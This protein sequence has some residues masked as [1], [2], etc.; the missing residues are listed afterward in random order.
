MCEEITP[1]HIVTYASRFQISRCPLL[2]SQRDMEHS[3]FHELAS[4]LRSRLT[5]LEEEHDRQVSELQVEI[6]QLRAFASGFSPRQGSTAFIGVD[7][8]SVPPVTSIGDGGSDD[9]VDDDG[10]DQAKH[11]FSGHGDPFLLDQCNEQA[12][13]HD[14]HQV[15]QNKTDVEIHCE[16]MSG[17]NTQRE[18][19]N[20]T[21]ESNFGGHAVE[22]PNIVAEDADDTP[23]ALVPSK[24]LSVRDM[25][26]T[27][28]ESRNMSMAQLADPCSSED[29]TK[30]YINELQDFKDIG[31]R[32]FP[33][34]AQSFS[35]TKQ[36]LSRFLLRPGS[37]LRICW[38]LLSISG[39]GFDMIFVPLQLSGLVS[40]GELSYKTDWFSRTFW[41]FD[42]CASFL[43][44]Y[45]KDGDLVMDWNQIVTNYCHT[46]LPF[47]MFVVGSDWVLFIVSADSRVARLTRIGKYLRAVRTLRLFRLQQSALRH[48]ADIF[49]SLVNDAVKSRFAIVKWLFLILIVYHFIACFWYALGTSN[50]NRGS[51]SWTDMFTSADVTEYRYV[52]SLQ[53]T[54]SYFA[55]T[56][57]GVYPKNIQER[58]FSLVMALFSLFVL[59]SLVSLV[60]SA[61]QSIQNAHVHEYEKMNQLRR[62][63]RAY[64][65][66]AELCER[67]TKNAMH[68][69]HLLANRIYPNH[70]ELLSVVSGTLRGE[71]LYKVWEKTFLKNRTLSLLCSLQMPMMQV[72]AVEA[73]TVEVLAQQDFFFRSNE[74]AESILYVMHG[75]MQYAPDSGLGS[76]AGTVSDGSGNVHSTVVTAVV[77]KWLCE[78]A[79][80]TSW[81]HLGDLAAS[82]VCDVACLSVD[83]FG[84]IARNHPEANNWLCLHAT[85]CVKKLNSR[86]RTEGKS[87][88]VIYDLFG[89]SA[90]PASGDNTSSFALWDR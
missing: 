14:G 70:V 40:D 90:Q 72:V 65:L 6:Q 78:V 34:R 82:C 1:V 73:L 59:S 24:G 55:G 13:D 27:G 61:V 8:A 49:D 43:T 41:T 53:W 31:L 79:L 26:S 3:R 12:S 32:T 62:F 38:D 42:I 58:L 2:V 21:W 48:S 22:N 56:S 67:V 18:S 37:T 75:E 30:N 39:L 89:F 69:H 15:P 54:M 51:P 60:T 4:E 5:R 76:Y 84:K 10:F 46:W 17:D 86:L 25:W 68:R 74:V 85:A 20:N 11:Y 45:Y 44:G 88:M 19:T 64:G 47:D 7:S 16:S 66:Q 57:G 9:S 87:S 71:I 52:T 28:E 50:R 81:I 33:T 36:K 83:E 80:W 77:K 63:F 35:A 23:N 29:E